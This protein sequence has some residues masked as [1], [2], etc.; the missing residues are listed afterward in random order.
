M[1]K[2]EEILEIFHEFFENKENV[3]ELDMICNVRYEI[4]PSFLSV[5]ANDLEE[6]IQ[7]LQPSNYVSKDDIRIFFTLS[8]N[9]TKEKRSLFT[10]G[11]SM[12]DD[13]IKAKKILSNCQ[14]YMQQVVKD[15]RPEIKRECRMQQ[16]ELP[17]GQLAKNYEICNVTCSSS[18]FMDKNGT[19][20]LLLA[21]DRSVRVGGLR[22]LY[23]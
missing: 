10:T 22:I 14:N 5:F 17:V 13:M 3:E 12:T 4:C 18:V 2:V 1:F 8:V 23:R 15:V 7:C 21:F 19:T 9:G 20:G 16:M 11:L 6:N